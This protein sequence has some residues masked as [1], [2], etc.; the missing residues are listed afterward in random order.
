MV[1]HT[2]TSASVGTAIVTGAGTITA[3]ILTQPTSSA[4]DMKTPVTLVDLAAAPAA[5]VS[6][7]VLFSACLA[8]LEFTNEPKPGMPLTPSLTAPAWPRPIASGTV[9][10]ANGCYVVSCPANVTVTVT[11]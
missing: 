11:A 9:A 6:P 1:D 4:V 8:A 3:M 5:G 10:F 2:V 7:K